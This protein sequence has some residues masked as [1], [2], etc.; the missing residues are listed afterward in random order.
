MKFMKW[1]M[2][3]QRLRETRTGI[4]SLPNTDGP[5]VCLFQSIWYINHNSR[6]LGSNGTKI[7]ILR[8]TLLPFITLASA[9]PIQIL[10]RICHISCWSIDIFVKKRTL[11]KPDF[12]LYIS[13]EIKSEI[14]IFGH[15]WLRHG[16]IKTPIKTPINVEV[17][18]LIIR[19]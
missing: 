13:S 14:T 16:P 7:I 15:I 5:P 8:I 10:R 18:P 12:I 6:I 4:Y 19:M 1:M 2:F 3:I 11:N 17:P 9:V